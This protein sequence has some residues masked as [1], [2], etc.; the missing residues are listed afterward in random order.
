LLHG[1]LHSAAAAAACECGRCHVVSVRR[2]LDTDLV[3]S[4]RLSMHSAHRPASVGWN[5]TQHDAAMGATS[6][7]DVCNA[8]RP[9]LEIVGECICSPYKFYNWLSFFAGHCWKLKGL[10]QQTLILA[11][12]KGRKKEEQGRD[13]VLNMH[14]WSNNRALFKIFGALSEDTYLY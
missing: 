3:H 10:P 11:K 6:P 1:R 5:L 8:S 7:R 12:F 14:G 13:W 2:K 9:T 4:K